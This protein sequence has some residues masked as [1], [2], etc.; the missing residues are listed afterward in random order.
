MLSNP[1]EQLEQQMGLPVAFEPVARNHRRE[2]AAPVAFV[3]PR[4][5][6]A[7]QFPVVQFPVVASLDGALQK[8]VEGFSIQE[9]LS[10]FR[11][12]EEKLDYCVERAVA[13]YKQKTNE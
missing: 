1:W 3:P 12:V 10:R 4:E 8:I 7:P 11:T 9:D 6:A 2:V 13:L 5:E